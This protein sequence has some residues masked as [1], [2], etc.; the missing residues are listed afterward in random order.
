MRFVRLAQPTPA[1]L[2]SLKATCADFG[3]TV[4]LRKLSG[5]L[6]GRVRLVLVSGTREQVRDALVTLD[7]LT[8]TGGSFAAPDS[9]FAWN[10]A[11]VNVCFPHPTN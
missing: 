4:R 9:R 8:S 7:A 3:A 6:S 5:S 1:L 2:A 10:G 11:E